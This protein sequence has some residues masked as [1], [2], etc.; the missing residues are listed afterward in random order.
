MTGKDDVNAQSVYRLPEVAR[1]H[2]PKLLCM[3][4][5]LSIYTKVY[6]M[7]LFSDPLT[8]YILQREEG[9]I[10][11]KRNAPLPSSPERKSKCV[12]IVDMYVYHVQICN[13]YTQYTNIYSI[14]C[15]YVQVHLYT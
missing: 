8:Y 15:T 13:M 11:L 12:Q 6:K 10:P 9:D 3:A 2:A 14:Q 7:F 1:S 5:K 4:I